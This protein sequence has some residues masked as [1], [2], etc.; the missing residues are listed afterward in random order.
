MAGAGWLCL[1]TLTAAVAASGTTAIIEA[2]SFVRAYSATVTVNPDGS[3]DV[4]ET[5][6]LSSGSPG[7]GL[8]DFT[9]TIAT[10]EQYDADNDR[11]YDLSTVEAT[12]D[13]A[14]ADATVTSNDG[15]DEIQ[16]GLAATGSDDAVV[17]LSYRV[18]G[19]VAETADG[20]EVRWPVI[21]GLDLPIARAAVAW[22]APDVVWLS[23]LAG[24]PGSSKPCTTSQLVDAPTPRMTQLDLEPGDQMVGIL[25]LAAGS[26]VEPS[27]E[28][29]PR[30]SLARSF[31]ASGT[32]LWLA[33]G[34]LVLGFVAAFGL[35]WARGRDADDGP[36]AAVDPLVDVGDG[37]VTL[38]PPGGV[39]P[40]Q[41]GTLVD[42][43][44]DVIDVTATIIDL[45][46][47][48][49]LF[50]EEI[51][52][53]AYGRMDW[54]L[55]RRNLGGDE[56]LG[57]EREILEALFVAGD[58]V[59]VS[60]LA[61]SL[62]DRLGGIQSLMYDDMVDQGWFA[63]R[64]DAVR[65]RWTTAGWVLVA[66]GVVLTVALALAGT[67]GLAGLAVILAGV[68]LAF[69]GQRAPARTSTGARLLRELEV[70]REWLA[71][72]DVSD[73]PSGQREQVISR[74]YG[75]ALVFGL[76]ERWAALLA[77]LDLDPDPDEPLYW[78]GAPHDWHLSD[79]A[80][81]L[82]HLTVSLNAA[83]GSRRLLEQT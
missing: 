73:V 54:R 2:E 43:H 5:Y 33:V 36:P 65:S 53:G 40:G 27:V 71:H 82:M 9:R 10:R 49:Y 1:V 56:L 12:V 8:P 66:A 4:E 75:Y 44:A 28:L 62:R 64:P 34:I 69:S 50:I 67:F 72:A 30:W 35:W 20:L 38:A 58:A 78:Y 32:P 22:N 18:T 11:V 48:N 42:E 80:P 46:T 68:A 63:E 52:R 31:T 81:S 13:G 17:Q 7:Q 3:L 14:A 83:V 15:V 23:C 37:R 21:Q 74:L 61:G 57:F 6:R 59:L 47:R 29:K 24:E 19:T 25:G 39:R 41:L 76:G 51:P 55:Q 60:E 16:V 45:A 77:E 26:G 70:F 79:A